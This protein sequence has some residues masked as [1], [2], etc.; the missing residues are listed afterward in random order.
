MKVVKELQDLRYLNWSKI[1]HSSGTA[2]T[3][4]KAEENSKEGKLYYKLSRFDATNNA[5]GHE[6][7][8][9]LIVDRLLNAINIPHLHYDLIHAKIVIDGIEYET[10]LN[11]SVDYKK[12]GEKKTAFDSF[13]MVNRKANESP[14]DFVIR[15][16]WEDYLYQMFIVDYL[17]LNRDRHGANIEVL[18]DEKGNIR[19]APLF[20]HGLSLL[21]DETNPSKLTKDKLL[22]DKKVMD[23]IGSGYTMEN[24]ALIPKE[25]MISL[26]KNKNDI[27]ES[28]FEDLDG[29]L[30][31]GF[32]DKIAEMISERWTFYEILRNKK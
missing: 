11:K 16:G 26:P 13:Y 18:K 19:L 5:F 27:V 24:L 30:I 25:K 12:K 21:Y 29:I 23:Y 15:N 10:Y 6:S 31:S 7:I 14:L 8:N 9:E 28:L 1:R 17:I 20:D 3:L 32:V 4:L 2:G 22:A